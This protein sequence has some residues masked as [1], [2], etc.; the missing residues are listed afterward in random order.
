MGAGY[1][2]DVVQWSKGEYLYATNTEDDT[3][4]IAKVA[5]YRTDKHSDTILNA[6]FLSGNAPTSSGIIERRGDSDLFGFYTGA[7][8]VTFTATP[9][10]IYP[11]LDV[12]LSLYDAA[13][14]LI[15]ATAPN[16]MSASLTQTLPQGTYYVCVEGAGAGDPST[17]YNDYGSLGQFTI[18]GSVISCTS[19]PPVAVADRSAPLSGRAPLPVN[20][21]SVGSGDT[22]GAIAS[23]SWDFG[24]GT[25]STA[26]LPVH[27]YTNPGTYVVSLIVKDNSGLSSPAD[28]V[29]VT[30]QK[31]KVLY[32]AKIGI[33]LASG[34][35]G[36][37]ATAKV[38]V[39]DQNGAAK[40]SATV[41][42]TWSGLTSASA[43]KVTDSVGKA[44]FASA[45][46]TNHGT[47]TFTV[48]NISLSGFTYASGQNVEVQDSIATP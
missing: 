31:A 16:T 15:T 12:Q 29:T 37:Q 18:N 4:K 30:V 19:K 5:G 28:T 39:F 11:N 14:D 1:Y 46:T 22:D 32:V 6:A 27:T 34:T 33:S 38:T 25:T 21:S 45:W 8:Q 47:F 43:S 40:P 44:N 20:F 17:S 7:G 3:A 13:G 35:K 2:A 41:F 24:D 10:S 36:Y 23:Y 26:A 48:T 9:A 42:G